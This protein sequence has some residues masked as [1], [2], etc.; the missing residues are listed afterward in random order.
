MTP[1]ER[2]LAALQYQRPS[3]GDVA[4]VAGVDNAPTPGP[5]SFMERLREGSAGAGG[6]AVA[7]AKRKKDDK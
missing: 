7:M 5:M 3:L 4:P 1:Q 2:L 6:G